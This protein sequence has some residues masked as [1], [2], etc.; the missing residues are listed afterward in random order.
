MIRIK[1]YLLFF[2]LLTF[3]IPLTAQESALHLD[4]DDDYRKALELMQKEKYSTAQ[5]LFLTVYEKNENVS[6]QTRTMSQYYIAYCAVRLFND[7]AEY[8]TY[9]FIGENPESQ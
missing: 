3:L 2:L 8:L 1:S 5:Q 4:E 6:S 9:K 7:D